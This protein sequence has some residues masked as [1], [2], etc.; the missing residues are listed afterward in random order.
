MIW[1]STIY[2]TNSE[3][4]NIGNYIQ[5]FNLVSSSFLACNFNPDSRYSLV[6]HLSK[7]FNHLQDVVVLNEDHFLHLHSVTYVDVE[8]EGQVG[9]VIKYFNKD[10]EFKQYV[11]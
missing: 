2:L 8:K 1:W 3:G 11:D 5:K 4:I 6:M 7:V 9:W 10:L